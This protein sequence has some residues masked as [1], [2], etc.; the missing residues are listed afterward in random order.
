MVHLLIL[1]SWGQRNSHDEAFMKY[2]FVKL[3]LATLFFTATV[4]SAQAATFTA[5]NNLEDI[6]PSSINRISGLVNEIDPLPSGELFSASD[7]LTILRDYYF[8]DAY[9]DRGKFVDRVDSE[10]GTTYSFGRG[11]TGFFGSFDMN[12][13]GEDSDGINTYRHADDLQ[14]TFFNNGQGLGSYTLSGPTSNAGIEFD[15]GLRIQEGSFDMFKVR[16][17]GG[18]ETFSLSNFQF[19]AAVPEP[20][21][22]A[23][24]LAGLGAIGYMSRRRRM[25]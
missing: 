16:S 17:L 21:T 23:M 8:N 10:Y 13:T 6:L 15:F 2:C 22:Y 18:V 14:F 12:P 7:D 24:L 1:K 5:S 3:A 19:A 25:S 20:Q 4:G 11:V 9:V